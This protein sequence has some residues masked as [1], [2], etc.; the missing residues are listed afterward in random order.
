LGGAGDDLLDGGCGLDR[1]EGGPGRNTLAG[2]EGDDAIFGGL[3]GDHIIIVPGSTDSITDPGGDDTLDFS[4][5]RRGVS[6]LLGLG[7]GA[8]QQVDAFENGLV[9]DGVFESVVGSPFDDQIHGNDADNM[10]DGGDGNDAL[11]GGGG[12]DKLDGG[13][14]GDA[15]DESGGLAIAAADL[16][17]TATRLNEGDSLE[18]SGRFNPASADDAHVVT[19][20]WGDGTPTTVIGV[21]AGLTNFGPVEHTF[22]DDNPTATPSDVNM[23]Q[24]SVRSADV[25]ATANGRFV[26]QM[27]LDVL[28]RP[29]DATTLATLT[30]QI[31]SGRTRAQVA[32]DLTQT[33][34]YRVNLIQ[35]LTARL[36]GRS[37]DAALVLAFSNP[38]ITDAQI[39]I[40]LVASGEYFA[41]AGGTNDDWVRQLFIDLLG[42]EVDAAALTTFTTA[43]TSGATRASVAGSV[44]ASTEYL[45]RVVN[46]LYQ[47]LLGRPADATALAAFTTL[48]QSGGTPEQVLAQIV[49]SVEYLG[50]V[51][52]PLAT[53]SVAA[54]VDN[55]APMLDSAAVTP[56]VEDGVATL[57]GTITD[58]GRGDTFQ[59]AS[60]WGDGSPAE[61]VAIA[62]GGTEFRATHRFRNEGAFNVAVRAV[63]DDGGAGDRGAT[64]T[65]ANADIIVTGAD[66]GGAPE[67]RV[68]D[69]TSKAIR[70][71]FLAYDPAFRG[72]VRVA[73]G[74]VNGDGVS[75]IITAPGAG[76]STVR[77]FSGVD[78][79][80][81]ASFNAYE[82][83]GRGGV[84][85]AAGDVNGDGLA[86]V[87][88]G[89]GKSSVPLVRVFDVAA[90]A[91][92]FDILAYETT[93]RGGVSV[94]A[95]DVNGDGLADIITGPVVGRA[96]VRVF[97]GRDA[98]L[99]AGF[100]AFPK[101]A[102]VGVCVAAGDVNGDG[103][104][105]IIVSSNASGR[106][107]VRV[108]DALSQRLIS[109]LFPYAATFRGAARVAAGDVNGDGRI[110][111][112]AGPSSGL[113]PLVRSFDP[114]N[115]AA[116]DEFLA[117]AAD[118]RG[119]L[120]IAGSVRR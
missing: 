117:D 78:A 83:R 68:F 34:E 5:A 16:A 73:A 44:V 35:D 91:S 79:S 93:L 90:G 81:V 58:P 48:L 32:F 3:D 56:A 21:A 55:V 60:N 25:P 1:L 6:V 7:D 38:A 40:A 103:R 94:A 92:L 51:P 20:A 89:P 105:D 119:G 76:P 114:L 57:T 66:A 22:S 112:L 95:G 99:L 37:A 107:T 118:V 24:V 102:R 69:A 50:R 70:F 61:T 100:I 47:Q 115:A 101:S 12:T 113:E 86:E 14:G 46:D 11:D 104:A 87:I 116:I 110:D 9:L 52:D 8:F 109:E 72:G 88:T 74:D 98:S 111:V 28:G 82:T 53:A 13:A 26:A 59:I 30:G 17:L 96:P 75:D 108:F 27:F 64:A 2:G 120:F 39:T 19:I 42:R 80:L 106:A 85:V 77:V 45:G 10:L 36:L 67:V 84:F 63:D 49:G 23:I 4:G 43:L 97:S 31:D 62:A 15:Y 71:R 65:I 33:N 54:T 41:L 18:L 29:V